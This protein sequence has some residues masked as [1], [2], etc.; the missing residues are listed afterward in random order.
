MML[1]KKTTVRHFK[2]QLTPADVTS[3]LQT[4][5]DTSA[6]SDTEVCAKP[7]TGFPHI[8]NLN[9]NMHTVT[10]QIYRIHHSNKQIKTDFPHL[11]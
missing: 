11:P 5:P 1:H 7:I 10:Q 4:S 9:Q 3:P 8:Q 2:T 6:S